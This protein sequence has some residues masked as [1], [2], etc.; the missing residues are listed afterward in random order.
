MSFGILGSEVQ[1]GKMWHAGSSA[2]AFV[3]VTVPGQ[4]VSCRI[5]RVASPGRPK[6]DALQLPSAT[7]KTAFFH[8]ARPNVALKVE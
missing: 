8:P 6:D 5:G 4:A 2:T 7:S 3:E 1:G